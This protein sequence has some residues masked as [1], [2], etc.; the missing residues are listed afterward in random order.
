L[1][2]QQRGAAGQLRQDLPVDLLQ[3]QHVPPGERPQ[4]RSQ[5]RRRPDT[6]EQRRHGTVAEQVHVLNTVR[7]GDHPRGQ[8]RDLHRG[9]HAARPGHPDV[10]P[11]QLIQ[12]RLLRQGHHRDQ[13]S[14]RHEVRVIKRRAGLRELMQQSHLRGVLSSSTTVAS[15]TPIVP[16][17]RTPFALTRPNRHPF[18]RWIEAYRAAANSAL[19][20]AAN[21]CTY[22]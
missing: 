2:G 8:A 5:R 11:G 13:A 19:R 12:A 6:P 18:T 20:S 7:P 3:L 15:A 22:S 10:L 14:L 16:A 1:A 21:M 9:V 4:E 17:Q